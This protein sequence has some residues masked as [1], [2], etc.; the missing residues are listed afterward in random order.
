MR[1]LLLLALLWLAAAHAVPAQTTPAH[2]YGEADPGSLRRV[3]DTQRADTARLRT[4][5]HLHDVGGAG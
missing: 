3:L 1:T 2:R 5:L 4:L